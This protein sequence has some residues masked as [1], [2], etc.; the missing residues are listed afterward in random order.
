MYFLDVGYGGA[1]AI[2]FD[3]AAEGQGE[4]GVVVACPEV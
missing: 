4:G 3:L 1:M 2:D